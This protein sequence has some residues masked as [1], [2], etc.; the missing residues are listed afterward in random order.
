[1]GPG[2]QAGCLGQAPANGL[3][4]TFGPQAMGAIGLACGLHTVA[5]GQTTSVHSGVGLGFGNGFLVG[6][7]P[8]VFF[9]LLVS[10]C[11]SA[12]LLGSFIPNLCNAI[13]NGIAPV[14]PTAIVPTPITGP[15][16]IVSAGGSGFG[17]VL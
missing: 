1:L 12:G 3:L 7:I 13:A 5:L 4:G 17:T 15:P 2:Y 14:I 8:S 6:A 10:Q 11:T 16:S 9:G